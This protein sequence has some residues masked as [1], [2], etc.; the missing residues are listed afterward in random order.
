[1]EYE[2]LPVILTS[3]LVLGE[4]RF[5][6]QL[7]DE[8]SQNVPDADVNVRTALLD[9]EGSGTLGEAEIAEYIVLELEGLETVVEH[10]HPDGSL[11]THSTPFGSGLYRANIDFPRSG[12]WGIEL[13]IDYAGTSETVPLVVTVLT[14]G[15]TPAIGQPAPPTENY[16][17]DDRPIA[18]LSSDVDPDEGLYQLTVAEALAERRAFVV[19]F[20]TPAFCH[21]RVCAPVLEAV[22]EVKA[23][24]PEAAYIHIEPFENLLDPANLRDSPFV[25]EW[26]L[27][28]EPWVFVVDAAGIVR[29]AFEG[30][31]TVE[32]LEEAV[33]GVLGQEEK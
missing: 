18:E 17:L 9:P 12:N 4:N 5:T 22:K 26:G 14:G 3:E 30:P 28:N 1:M 8:N 25:A 11:H 27:P 29:A 21:S 31:F 19:A 13:E 23:R 10:E 20:A 16:T 2:F 15:S 6:F 33:A 7:L 24:R 32:E